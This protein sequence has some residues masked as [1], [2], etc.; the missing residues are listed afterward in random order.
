MGVL[1]VALVYFVARAWFKSAPAGLAAALLLAIA[2]FHVFYSQE[3]RPYSLAVVAVLV[4]L[5]LFHHALERRDWTGWLL[6]GAGLGVALYA[7]YFLAL[8]VVPAGVTLAACRAGEW[9]RSGLEAVQFLVACAVGAA[10]FSPWVIY[11]SVGQLHDLGWPPPPPLDV[12]R[13]FRVFEVL[14]AAAYGPARPTEV[15]LTMA[16]LGLVAL[17]FVQELRKGNRAVLFL[18]L[19]PAVVIPVVWTADQREHY[20]WAERQVIFL[21]PCLCLL[22]VAGLAA[23]ATLLGRR[24]AAPAT[25]AAALVLVAALS[26]VSVAKVYAGRFIPKE[27]WRDASHFAASRTHADTRVYSYLSSVFAY[28]VAYY[29]PSLEPRGRVFEATPQGVAGLDLQAD[30]LVVARDDDQVAAALALRSFTY[31]EFPGGVRV[32]FAEPGS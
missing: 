28:G 21:L 19:L 25:A 27:D 23:L 1:A 9:R 5:L 8:L 18:G 24:R 15:V 26:L 2:P 6:F 17:G 3:A 22:A 16:G 4:M 30:D 10:I 29:E 12:R 13:L 7:H 31:R 32:Y 14:I 20:F 11:A